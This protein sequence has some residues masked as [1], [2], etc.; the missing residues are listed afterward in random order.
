MKSQMKYV[1]WLI[2]SIP[3]IG[4]TIGILS[5]NAPVEEMLHPTG[6]FSAR[7]MIIAMLATPLLLLFRQFGWSLK[8]PQW[9]VRNRRAF[10]VAAFGYALYHTVLYVIDAGT[11]TKILGEITELGIW[12]GWLAFLI[13]VPLAITSNDRSVR[14][15]K[16]VWKKLQRWVYPAAVLTLLHWMFVHNDVG[17][18]L[19]HFVPLA[20]LELYRVY[21][22]YSQKQ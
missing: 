9:L 4:F 16:S 17:P 8:V 11:L 13:F 6:E 19:V 14:A 18:A 22:N 20:A 1:L 10:G 7:F 3:A 2:L 15:M 21:H 5:G 12:T